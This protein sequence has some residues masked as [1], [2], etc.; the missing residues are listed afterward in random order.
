MLNSLL[1]WE[2]K[3]DASPQ[4]GEIEFDVSRSLKR[5]TNIVQE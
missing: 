5:R 3:F 1:L 4:S 2:I